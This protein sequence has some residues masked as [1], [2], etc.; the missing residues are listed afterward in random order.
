MIR[1][2]VLLAA[3]GSR[4]DPSVNLRVHEIASQLR[5]RRV[6]D[7]IE[8]GF[9]QGGPG[10]SEAF[11]RL[12]ADRV[13]VVPLFT[14]EGYYTRT[15]LPAALE[16][17][18][19]AHA[20]I[21]YTPPL[22]TIP[23]MAALVISRIGALLAAHR[24]NPCSTAVL[25]VGHGTRRNP[26]SR[27][28][29]LRLA[30]QISGAGL[31]SWVQAGFLDDDPEVGSVF[32]SLRD[33]DVLVIPFLIGGAHASLDLPERLGTKDSPRVRR[34]VFDQPVGS[35]TEIPEVLGEVVEREL[36]T[37]LVGTVALVGAGPGDPGLITVRGLELLR[38]ADVILHDR[39]ASPD[40][41]REIKPGAIIIDVGKTPGGQSTTQDEIN[42]TLLR[43]AQLGRRVVR[44]KGGDP[45]VFGRGA[46]EV[47]ACESAGIRCLVVPGVSSAIA[48]PAAA[49]IPVT[50]RG[51][52]RSFAVVTAQA[53]GE[54]S[55]SLSR[56][57]S[58]VEAI[59][60]LVVLMGQAK[61]AEFAEELIRAGRAANT[62]VACIQDGTTARQRVATGTLETIVEVVRREG[63]TAPL[64]T[65]IGM[66]AERAKREIVTC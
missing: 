30:N 24:L 31:V 13:L 47:D 26:E 18:G 54:D 28:T 61:L 16:E 7:A 22:G 59:D 5:E 65:V 33:Q 51:E 6:A 41:L 36:R 12:E 49:G 66:V 56:F 48:V 9:H 34:V 44:L 58:G 14:S 10:F 39:L 37:P 32:E 15:V 52:A 3:H 62:P 45:F 50:C 2:G 17:A 1:T 21:G 23:A 53:E 57:A 55:H 63:L 64:V 46:E 4:R 27:V 29:T 60:T 35:Y 20:R 43:H 42:A 11:E 8:A 19:R 38:S 40:L 25:L